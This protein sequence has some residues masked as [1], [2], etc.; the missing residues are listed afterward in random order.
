[1]AD[2]TTKRTG[3]LL[4][5]LFQI[6]LEHPEGMQA[7]DALVAL[8]GRVE[9]TPYEQGS[10]SHGERRFEKIVRFATVDTTKAGWLVKAKGRWT[11]T[12]KGKD[13]L[14]ELKDPERFYADAARLYRAWKA[15]RSAAEE[16]AAAAEAVEADTVGE[17]R[18]TQ[19]FEEADEQAW[20]EVERY[21]RQMDPYELQHLVASLLR[22]MGYHVEWV[23]D[24]GKDGGVDVL[25]L[26]D[27]LGTRPPRIK[28]QVK[29]TQQA[30]SVDSLRSFMALLGEGDVGIFVSIGGFTRDAQMEARTQ[31]KR[32]VTL[33]NADRL[34]EMWT[35]FYPKLDDTSRARL[36]IK[37]IYFLA[38][39][40]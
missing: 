29:R 25:A 6:L 16:P 27:P 8:S 35:E 31:E 32:R 24:P 11:V 15:T 38:P 13:A 26:T 12:D 34:F 1:M 4:R 40:E 14:E 17:R 9:L 19:T 37:P 10:Y 21:L 3:E 28:V 5:K 23:A 22:A 36:P 39:V 7:K 30:T 18:V 20:S 2:V 33:I